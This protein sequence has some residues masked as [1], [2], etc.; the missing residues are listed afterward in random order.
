M[1]VK[2]NTLDYVYL[3]IYFHRHV[4]LL[5]ISVKSLFVLRKWRFIGVVQPRENNKVERTVGM[6]I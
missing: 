3:F 2:G 4:D 5:H 6:G 1:I